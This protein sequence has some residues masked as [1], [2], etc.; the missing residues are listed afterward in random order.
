RPALP[1]PAGAK[2]YIVDPPNGRQRDTLWGIAERHLGNPE[3]WPEIFQLNK[4]RVGAN[5][6]MSNPHWIYAGEEL[7]MPADAVGLEAAGVASP[8]A[9][10]DP[11]AGSADAPVP[12]APQSSVEMRVVPDGEAQPQAGAKTADRWRIAHTVTDL[13]PG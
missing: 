6:R 5:H 7:I 10:A 8:V 12:A 9:P 2:R 11:A 13:L 1:T 4:G 3:R